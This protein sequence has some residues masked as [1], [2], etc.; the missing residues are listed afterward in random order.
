MEELGLQPQISMVGKYR[1]PQFT[2]GKLIENEWVVLYSSRTDEGT[3]PN[4]DELEGTKEIP[5]AELSKMAEGRQMTPDSKILIGEFLRTSGGSDD[6]LK[7]LTDL[8][9]GSGRVIVIAQAD[10]DLRSEAPDN[11][12]VLLKM[13]QSSSAAGGRGGGFGERRVTAVSVFRSKGGKWTKV[14]EIVDEGRAQAF[15]IPYYVSRLPFVLKDGSESVG[16]GVVDP[17]LTSALIS[18]IAGQ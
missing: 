9:I 14:K 18:R 5:M 15:E 17:E 1:M 3:R 11:T 6:D 8:V 10:V 16:Y 4:P 13:V 12:L 2:D 7:E